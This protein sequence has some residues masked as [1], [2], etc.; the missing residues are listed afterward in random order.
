MT[1]TDQLRSVPIEG[2]ERAYFVDLR[3]RLDAL[4]GGTYGMWADEIARVARTHGRRVVSKGRGPGSLEP[5]ET[6]GLDYVVLDGPGIYDHLPRL[7]WLYSDL[8]GEVSRIVGEPVMAGV[9][10]PSCINV[11]YLSGQGARYELH[12]D[13][14]P[15]TLLL[16]VTSHEDQADNASRDY[17]LEP[18]GG[19]LLL[20]RPDRTVTPILPRIG[21]GIIFDGAAIPHAV[22]PLATPGIRISVPMVYVPERIGARPAGLDAHLYGR[23][24]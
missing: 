1:P 16:F 13:A 8:E 9:H 7:W 18:E 10:R 14:Q 2:F 4:Y 12:T 15:Y 23:E 19:R 6:A 21:R 17:G 5:E 3:Y 24:R 22:E 11:N 20:Q